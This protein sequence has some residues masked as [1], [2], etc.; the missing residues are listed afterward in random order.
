MLVRSALAL[1]LIITLSA[2]ATELLRDPHAACVYVFGYDKRDTV[3]TISQAD[4]VL[5]ANEWAAKFY[6]DPFIQIESSDFRTKPTRYWLFT[7]RHSETG[8]TFFAIV[9]PDGAFVEPRVEEQS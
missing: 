7:L 1:L 4:A 3:A 9:L 6:G 2:R 5:K 8:K